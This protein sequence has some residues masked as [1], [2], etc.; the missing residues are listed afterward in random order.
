M[1]EKERESEEE[2]AG[3]KGGAAEAYLHAGAVP[4]AAEFVLP[5]GRIQ[6]GPLFAGL[7]VSMAVTVLLTALGRGLTLTLGPTGVGGLAYW[8]IGV[9][10]IGLFLGSMLAARQSRAT[11]VS[12]GVGHGLVIWSL[13]LIADVVFGVVGFFS[14][15]TGFAE[16]YQSGG[17]MGF[18]GAWWLFI[19]YAILLA[20]AGIGG[21]VG[22]KSETE[23]EHRQT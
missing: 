10:A 7:A 14:R 20:A 17:L 19:G 12:T 8:M 2:Q 15:M 11:Q 9:A 13:F 4:R 22:V 1:E 23:Q 3:Q 18:V 16:I 21:A 6:W 5:I